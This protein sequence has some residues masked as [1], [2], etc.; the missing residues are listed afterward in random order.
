[1]E[2]FDRTNELSSNL[3]KSMVS[4]TGAGTDRGFALEFEFGSD[5]SDW[6]MGWWF[7]CFIL[8]PVSS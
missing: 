1:M 4:A 8:E 2:S 7:D 6:K 3:S 5:T